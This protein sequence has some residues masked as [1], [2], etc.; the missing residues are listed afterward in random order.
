MIRA[1][2]AGEAVVVASGARAVLVACAATVNATQMAR[3]IQAT[4]GFVQVALR[5]S[6]CDTLF[7]PEAVPTK[8]VTTHPAYGQCVAADAAAGISTGISAT[9]RARTARVL[10]SPRSSAGDL[11]RPG[12]VVPMRVRRGDD[13]L[14][15]VCLALTERTQPLAP[16]A[17]MADLVSTSSAGMADVAEAA[18][19]AAR[20]GMPLLEYRAEV[21]KR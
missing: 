7:L 19:F 14:A 16:G 10:A 6:T 5:E 3:L 13:S 9:D 4:S 1:L 20:H 2:G 18:A 11:I 15:A 12:H 17:V 21:G 8:R